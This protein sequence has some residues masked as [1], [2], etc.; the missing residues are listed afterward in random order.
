MLLFFN[1]SWQAWGSMPTSWLLQ[2]RQHAHTWQRRHCPAWASPFAWRPCCCRLLRGCPINQHNQTDGCCSLFRIIIFFTFSFSWVC[3]LGCFS[4][5]HACKYTVHVQFYRE[6]V[7]FLYARSNRHV[8]LSKLSMYCTFAKNLIFWYW[9]Y[10]WIFY[11]TRIF[12]FCNFLW[13]ISS[14]FTDI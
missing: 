1:S 7:L 12:E 11:I 8:F 3:F 14:P 10:T 5:L 13:K 9:P 6:I 2:W 4:S